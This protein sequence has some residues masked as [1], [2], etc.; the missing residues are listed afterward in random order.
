MDGIGPRE[1]RPRMVNNNWGGTVE[2]NR[3]RNTR[4]PE[5]VRNAGL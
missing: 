3:L 2:D 5:L 4:I 1:K